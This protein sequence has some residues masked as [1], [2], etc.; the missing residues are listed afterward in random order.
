MIGLRVL[1]L[2][3]EL[4]AV[5][6]ESGAA[7][8]VLLAKMISCRGVGGLASV[9]TLN[10]KP[11]CP[12]NAKPET[13]L[14]GFGDFLQ[15][16]MQDCWVNFLPSFEKSFLDSF[17][18]YSTSAQHR[19][20]TRDSEVLQ[21]GSTGDFETQKNKIINLGLSKG[22]LKGLRIFNCKP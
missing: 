12:E 1:G 15:T 19:P 8:G 10:S 21:H 16:R 13:R 14:R 20:A 22:F 18:F 3:A 7:W 11:L 5:A 6:S 17:F 9:L 4:P 2:P